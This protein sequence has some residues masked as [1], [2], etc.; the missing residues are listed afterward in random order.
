MPFEEN[1][2]KKK[3]ITIVL[4][5][6]L[7]FTMMSFSL[8]A[9]AAYDPTSEVSVYQTTNKLS[10]GAGEDITTTLRVTNNSDYTLNNVQ[11]SNLVPKGYHVVSGGA[12]LKTYTTVDPRKSVTLSTTFESD[13]GKGVPKTGD[14]SH[15][16]FY[17]IACAVSAALIFL[18]LRSKKLHKSIVTVLIVCLLAGT[19]AAALENGAYAATWYSDPIN[20][21]TYVTVDGKTLP[22][23]S[24]AQF[25]ITEPDPAVYRVIF[26][27]NGGEGTAMQPQTFVYGT[28][29]KLSLNTYTNPG[30]DFLG[31]NTDKTATEALYID[32]QTVSDLTSED[33]GSVTLYAIWKENGHVTIT[34][35]SANTN[36]GTVSRESEDLAPVGGTAEGSTATPATGH[37]FVNWTD[38]SGAEVSRN[39]QFVPAK[40]SGA[41][42]EAVYTANFEP[43]TY[44]ITY[45]DRGGA[46][47]SGT[48]DSGAPTS[49]T[50]GTLTALK[51][52][53]KAGDIEFGGWFIASDCTGTA[54]TQLAPAA[55]T[56][57][58]TLY[59]KWLNLRTGITLS[60]SDYKYGADNIPAPQL[61]PAAGELEES[62]TVNYYCRAKGSSDEWQKW[63][64]DAEALNTGDYE[65]KAEIAATATY[66]EATVG[67][68]DFS[69]EKGT[70][71]FTA[72]A[73]KTGLKFNGEAQALITAG[74]GS[75]A[76]KYKTGAEGE[77]SASIPAEA[78]HGTYT[79]YF[80]IDGD[81]NHDEY[82]DETGIEVKIAKADWDVTPPEA[83][84][85]TYDGSD[86]ELVEAG[87]VKDVKGYT[88]TDYTNPMLYS[89]DG[90]NYSEDIPTGINAGEYTVYY[91][92]DGKGNYNGCEDYITVKIGK[93]T[94]VTWTPIQVEAGRGTLDFYPAFSNASEVSGYTFAVNNGSGYT[95]IDPDGI[96]MQNIYAALDGADSKT[97]YFRKTS[98][99]APVLTVYTV[100]DKSWNSVFAIRDEPVLEY[101]IKAWDYAFD[102]QAEYVEFGI[103]PADLGDPES[104][105]GVPEIN[106]VPYPDFYNCYGKNNGGILSE[107]SGY[108]WFRTAES[109]RNAY[110]YN[111]PLYY[112][113][114]LPRDTT[115]GIVLCTT[116]GGNVEP[117]YT[118][119]FS[120]T[121]CASTPESITG[122]PEGSEISVNGN[123]FTVIADGEAFASRTVAP[124]TGYTGTAVWDPSSGTI[125]SDTEVTVSFATD[126]SVKNGYMVCVWDM[127]R[128]GGVIFGPATGAEKSCLAVNKN[129][130]HCIACE[131]WEDIIANI[132]AGHADFYEGCM[133][134]GCTHNVEITG[135]TVF[136][137]ADAQ[138]SVFYT[139]VPEDYRKWNNSYNSGDCESAN[140]ATSLI[141]ATLNGSGNS[142]IPSP[143][144]GN[145][146]LEEGTCLLSCFPEEL[147]DSITA[148]E[149][150]CPASWSTASPYQITKSQNA[151]DK[152]WLANASEIYG[153]ASSTSY[154]DYGVQFT[155]SA[156]AGTS[157]QS[158]AG[159]IV[160]DENGT[161]E[162]SWLRSPER[163]SC[164]NASEI[165]I[166]GMCAKNTVNNAGVGFAPFFKLGGEE[167]SSAP[168]AAGTSFTTYTLVSDGHGAW[169][170]GDTAVT[171]FDS[172]D[173]DAPVLENGTITY[174]GKDGQQHTIKAIPNEGYK[175]DTC[176]YDAGI[177]TAAFKPASF[178]LSF[179]ATGCQTAPGEITD[180]PY[181]S[182]FTADGNTI[183][184][185]A[186]GEEFAT[187]TV[188]PGTGYTGTAV[189]DPYEGSITSDT[190]VS[191]SFP[192]AEP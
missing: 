112:K 3:V 13:N 59:A 35:Q 133:E 173:A 121:G 169:M 142:F 141:R 128:D 187:R 174:T 50:Y 177:Y 157:M 176:T 58:I 86:Q 6:I 26:N 175:S 87:T 70:W 183:T 154:G 162:A 44:T 65:M 18:L 191:V 146:C 7:A 51:S 16:L 147:R 63:T 32:G 72:P 127:Q 5:L 46:N 57:S 158:Y 123:T 36:M 85:L 74:S 11:L 33:G 118:I 111:A 84:T 97:L 124:G 115:K 163:S 168:P 167:P 60:M 54:V 151:V 12:K 134:D 114:K 56:N 62:P 130:E 40:T 129:H 181:G 153:A 107:N 101:P 69:V 99:S 179:N 132:D 108:I 27:A 125:D 21:T 61:T 19:G 43:Q 105:T 91:K 104:L 180:I 126:Y 17:F 166:S 148:R 28:A 76:F 136:I 79:V 96:S 189:W 140:Y 170:E 71:K 135:N 150:Q 1:V 52:A 149:L 159:N 24:S 75:D 155:K 192:E 73:A 137:A 82:V 156:A 103:L 185:I 55:Y 66:K 20:L 78:N 14:S 98:D 34:Y 80:K 139:S 10:Y 83:K 131:S 49:H 22:V 25:E 172:T 92:V 164:T 188:S 90:E 144:A 64:D 145:A 109:D 120:A 95:E 122:I 161:A 138:Y 31:W 143:Y 89:L 23:Y 48:H 110:N 47:F 4:T 77:Y 152:L 88:G 171:S 106:G 102:F 94:P 29:Q 67:P 190:S 113:Y 42:V 45:K 184:V 53:T 182:T 68:V 41:Y 117:T 9:M 186:A 178:T 8:S 30:Y 93:A 39:A 15:P 81:G 38:A 160:F 100:I 116:V 2:M 165:Y 119:T 37:N